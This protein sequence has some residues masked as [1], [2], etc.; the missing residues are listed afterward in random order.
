MP[1][2]DIAIESI[3]FVLGVIVAV[4]LAE[5]IDWRQ[6]RTKERQEREAWMKRKKHRG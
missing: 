1:W 4:G 2:G 5:Y 3:F 6:E